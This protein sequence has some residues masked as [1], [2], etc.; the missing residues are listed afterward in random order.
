LEV[1]LSRRIAKGRGREFL[2]R[3]LYNTHFQ[4]GNRRLG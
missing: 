3:T 2:E 4:C 1:F